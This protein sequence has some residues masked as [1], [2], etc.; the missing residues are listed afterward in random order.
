MWISKPREKKQQRTDDMYHDFATNRYTYDQL[1]DK[2]GMC[3]DYIQQ[4]LDAYE[5]PEPDPPK[6]K[7]IIVQARIGLKN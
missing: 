7:S 1:K 3:K 5:L 4:H 2:Y 6:K